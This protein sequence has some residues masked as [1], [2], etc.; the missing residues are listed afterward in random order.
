MYKLTLRCVRLSIFFA[1]KQVSITYSEHVSVA[2]VIQHAMRMRRY[3]AVICG[4][5]GSLIFFHII[6]STA[7][8]T[9]KIKTLMSI[10]CVLIFSMNFA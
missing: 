5:S 2:L 1:E 7:R 8:F 10:K 6:S 4:L 3:Y 9:T